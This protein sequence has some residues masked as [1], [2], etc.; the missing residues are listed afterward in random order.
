MVTYH[1]PVTK[2][3]PCMIDKLGMKRAKSFAKKSLSSQGEE[4]RTNIGVNFV[5]LRAS[6]GAQFGYNLVCI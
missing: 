5:L 3:V 1:P 2:G 4:E 6:Q